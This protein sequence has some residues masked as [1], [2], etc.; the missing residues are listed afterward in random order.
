MKKK[1]K[2]E[3]FRINSFVTNDSS[4]DSET[5]KGG[6]ATDNCQ[7]VGGCNITQGC[8]S[9]VGHHTHVAHQCSNAGCYSDYCGTVRTCPGHCGSVPL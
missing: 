5:V 7:S 3:K 6:G 8:G 2:L 1:I 9:T 4:F